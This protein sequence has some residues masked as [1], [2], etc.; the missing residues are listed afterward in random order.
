MAGVLGVCALAPLPSNGADLPNI[1]WLTTEDIGPQLGCYGDAYALTPN[2]DR[3]AERSLR[4]RNAWANAPVCAPARTTIITG[5]YATSTGA[6]HMRSLVGMPAFMRMYPQFLRERGYYCS[7]NSKE[8]YN[9]SKPAAV[10]HD[11]SN[12]A[13]WKNRAPGQPFFAIFNFTVT[14]ESQIRHRPHTLQHD[15]AK[16]PLPAY[17]PDTPEV[18]HDWAQYYDNITT[19]DTQAGQ[20]LRELAD[21]GLAEDTIVFFY[22]DHGSGMPRSKRWP[23]NSG[24]HVPLIVHVPEKFK[25]LAPKDYQSGGTTDRL[26]GFVDLA[27]TLLSL[28]GIQPP[29]WMQG[30]AFMGR[31]D[32]PP[33][34]YVFGFRGRMDERYDLVR[35]VRNGRFIYVRNYMPHLIYGQHLAYMFETPTTQ[36][37]K[38]MYDERK[39]K[40]PKTIFWET[41]PPEELYDLQTDPD[42]VRNL[43]HSPEHEAVLGELRQALREHLLA[44]RDVGFLPEAEMHRR[45]AGSTPYD[46]GQDRTNYPFDRILAMAEFASSPKP[47]VATSRQSAETLTASRERV[48]QDLPKL[49]DGLKDNDSAVRYWAVLGLLMR[50]SNG[51]IAARPELRAVLKDGS[52]SVR[53]AASRALAVHGHADDLPLVLDTLKELAPPDK[54]GVFVSVEALSVIE[55]LG[56]KAAPL[57]EFL[58]TLPQSDPQ[59]SGRVSSYVPRLLANLLGESVAPPPAPKTGKAKRAKLNPETVPPTP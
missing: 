6:E 53:I 11:S 8:D 45:A 33:S 15:P 18:R 4:Y 47:T 46:L 39:L 50:G 59:A 49:Q 58:R 56:D 10:W 14:H 38:K 26:V 40:P 3:L 12:K 21:A 2:L 48:L 16:A 43:A 25:N 1:L 35:S 9:L 27:P 31:F 19:M 54:N 51:V 55:A 7:N 41:K 23:Y 52:P 17:H 37:W 13:H 24:L 20:A 32:T 34:R 29:D 36:V 57:R 28:A 30:R 42:E 44:T 5:V 22:G